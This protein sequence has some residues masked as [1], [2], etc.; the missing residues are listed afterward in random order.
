VLGYRGEVFLFGLFPVA[1]IA[2]PMSLHIKK[3][4]VVSYFE[5]QKKPVDMHKIMTELLYLHDGRKLPAS[6]SFM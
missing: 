1:T 6:T 4:T 5:R 2:I 3:S